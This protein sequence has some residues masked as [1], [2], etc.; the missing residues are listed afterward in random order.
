MHSRCQVLVSR[1]SSLPSAAESKHHEAHKEQKQVNMCHGS[2]Q[3]ET[4]RH[5]RMRQPSMRESSDA[6]PICSRALQEQR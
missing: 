3:I 5:M 1:C 6:L 4:F 2:A